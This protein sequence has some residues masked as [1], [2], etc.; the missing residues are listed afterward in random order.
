MFG[1]TALSLLIAAGIAVAPVVASAATVIP[2]GPYKVAD[3]TDLAY[4]PVKPIGSVAAGWVSGNTLD[5]CLPRP[6]PA[7]GNAPFPVIVFIHGGGWGYGVKEQDTDQCNLWASYGFA[8]FT[9]NYRLV[10]EPNHPGYPLSAPM[11]DAQL[12]VRWIRSQSATFHIYTGFMMGLGDSAGGSIVEQLAYYPGI[13]P[14]PGDAA[15]QILASYSSALNTIIAEF[16]PS[17]GGPPPVTSTLLWANCQQP[18]CQGSP[19]TLVVQGDQDVTVPRINSDIM[20]DILVTKGRLATEY[21]YAGA[22]EF[23]GATPQAIHDA[24]LFELRW[25]IHAMRYRGFALPLL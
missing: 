21:V 20:Y 5:A 2:N 6:T 8:A 17:L 11:V 1:P 23:A 24:K 3:V 9:I 7:Q 10:P 16:G 18:G 15:P 4:G 13:Y 12:A 14:M 19:N 22:H 25:A